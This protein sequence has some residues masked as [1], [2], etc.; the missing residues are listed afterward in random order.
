MNTSIRRDVNTP[1]IHLVVARDR[2]GVIGDG[3]KMLWSLRD[4]LAYFKRVTMGAPIVMGR[5]TWN[6]IGRPLP[7]RRNI[8]LSRQAGLQLAGADVFDS[9]AAIMDAL[10]DEPEIF[11]IGGGEIY[12]LFLEVADR[13]HITEVDADVEG[14]TTF[15][16]VDLER[17]WS[18]IMDAKHDADERNEY[19]F[20]IRVYRRIAADDAS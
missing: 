4:D 9:P 20:R 5:R 8:V 12:R 2:H 10:K 14:S 19:P 17:G 7:G 18:R 16:F 1:C 6:S 13:L 11:I 3:E 15:P